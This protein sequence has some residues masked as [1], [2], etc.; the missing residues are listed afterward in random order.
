MRTLKLE[1]Q[2]LKNNKL[3]RMIR[4]MA[5]ETIDD[6]NKRDAIFSFSEDVILDPREV[7]NMEDAVSFQSSMIL[8]MLVLYNEYS[9]EISDIKNMVRKIR[10][11][12]EMQTLIDEKEEFDEEEYNKEI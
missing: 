7:T 6:K 3:A 4:T 2:I 5:I 9:S 11:S 12:D 1:K 8:D 10:H